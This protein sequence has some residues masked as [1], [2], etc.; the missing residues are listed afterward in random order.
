ME[1]PP[2]RRFKAP[3]QWH[4]TD[5]RTAA[6]D[7]ASELARLAELHDQIEGQIREAA[8]L[9]LR[10][11]RLSSPVSGLIRMNLGDAFALILTHERRHLYQLRKVTEELG[12]PKR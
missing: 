9:D 7:P 8:G 3:K 12:Y 10:R 1:P 11:I 2:R 4:P 6:L 5:F